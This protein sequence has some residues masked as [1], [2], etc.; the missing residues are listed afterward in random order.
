MGAHS[1]WQHTGADDACERQ[2]E[3]S[4]GHTAH[5]ATVPVQSQFPPVLPRASDGPQNRSRA[6]RAS[7]PRLLAH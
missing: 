6:R 7:H 5:R 2:A 1:A 3:H 4:T